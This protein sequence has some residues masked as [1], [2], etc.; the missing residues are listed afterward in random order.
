MLQRGFFRISLI[1]VYRTTQAE[2]AVCT[3][4]PL[5]NERKRCGFHLGGEIVV[6]T[7]ELGYILSLFRQ[8]GTMENVSPVIC[9]PVFNAG[10]ACAALSG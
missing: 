3:V 6:G 4:L 1:E 5:D 10:F 9:V 2:D 7:I 8:S